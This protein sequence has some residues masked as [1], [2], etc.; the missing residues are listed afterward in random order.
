MHSTPRRTASKI[1]PELNVDY[2]AILARAEHVVGLLRTCYICEGWKM[3]EKAASR[4]LQYFRNRA[5]G[6]RENYADWKA[7]IDF[8]K[9]HGQS[10]DWICFGDPRGMICGLAAG[11]QRA[12]D[13]AGNI[14][15]QSAGA[16]R[17]RE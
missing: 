7:T 17:S 16:S 3:D 12:V 9:S 6:K 2:G 10:L 5:E 15:T 11:S 8:A 4:M 13:V 1:K 14:E